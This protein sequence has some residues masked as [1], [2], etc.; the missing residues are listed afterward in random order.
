MLHSL[1]YGVE[2]APLERSVIE[3]TVRLQWAA[4]RGRQEFVEVMLRTQKASLNNI[5]TAAKSGVPLTIDQM[6]K[7]EDLL[8]N[9]GEEF[10]SLD[11]EAAFAHVI[12]RLPHLAHAHQVWL[13]QSR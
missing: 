11:Y 6:A 1:G 4:E 2:G 5:T 9:A 12:E 8:S 13:L 3:H 7:V 10:K